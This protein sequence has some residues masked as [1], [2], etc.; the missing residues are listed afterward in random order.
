LYSG[1]TE[2]VQ[3]V[4]ENYTKAVAFLEAKVNS[5][6]GLMNVTLPEDWGRQAGGE[7]STP[8][9]ALLYRVSYPPQHS[10]CDFHVYP[11]L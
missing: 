6:L 8:G 10:Y 4:W 5:D 7:F 2:W 1:D 3:S 11:R 9:N